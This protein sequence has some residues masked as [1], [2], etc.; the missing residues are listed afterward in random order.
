MQIKLTRI[1]VIRLVLHTKWVQNTILSFTHL[2]MIKINNLIKLYPKTFLVCFELFVYGVKKSKKYIKNNVIKPLPLRSN[3]TL[4]FLSLVLY[5]LA[6]HDP[7]IFN[8]TLSLPCNGHSFSTI[9]IFLKLS[10]IN[11]FINGYP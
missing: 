6:Q 5:F 9:T 10:E 1:F 2:Y 8:W 3:Y 4:S 7:L 11:L